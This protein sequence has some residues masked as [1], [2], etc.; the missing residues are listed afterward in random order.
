MRTNGVDTIYTHIHI[1]MHSHMHT[2]I[3]T[4]IHITNYIIMTKIIIIMIM[5]MLIIILIII[6][7]ILT[8][9]M[10]PW[11]ALSSRGVGRK[12]CYKI[13][14]IRIVRCNI[15]FMSIVLKYVQLIAFILNYKHRTLRQMTVGCGQMGSTLMGP[16]QK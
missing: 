16:L 12:S 10:E 5:L 14:V 8:T 1:N 3:H 9:R 7:I 6:T 11:A 2:Y 13:C 4:C 15:C